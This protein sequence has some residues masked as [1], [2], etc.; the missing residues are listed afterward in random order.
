MHDILYMIFKYPFIHFVYF[1]FLF[2]FL[3]Y[4]YY[5]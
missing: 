1:Y 3:S 4:L 2:S 5:T